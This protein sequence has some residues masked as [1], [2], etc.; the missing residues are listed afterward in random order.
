VSQV[1]LRGSL[2]RRTL[3]TYLVM[4]VGSMSWAWY[5]VNLVWYRRNT[6]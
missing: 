3:E 4:Q 6:F 2:S 5:N 1:D